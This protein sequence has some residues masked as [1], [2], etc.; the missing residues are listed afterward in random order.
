[1]R[2]LVTGATGFLGANLV[3]HLVRRGDTVRVLTR[4]SSSMALL[5]GVPVEVAVGDV[6]DVGSLVAAARGVETIYHAAALV[7]YW[8]R[9][10]E[11]QYLVNVDGVRN[12]I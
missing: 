12:V 6:A 11:R 5:D 8:R 10:R 2:V 1:M 3:H 9:W 4:P 7:S